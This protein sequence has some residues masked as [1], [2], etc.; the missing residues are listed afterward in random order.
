LENETLKSVLG[1]EQ[2]LRDDRS[3]EETNAL[4][5]VNDDLKQHVVTSEEEKKKVKKQRE[6]VEVSSV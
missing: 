3:V 1:G 2:E 4:L 5:V 6:F